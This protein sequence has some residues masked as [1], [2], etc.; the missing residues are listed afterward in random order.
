MSLGTTHILFIE[1]TTQPVPLYVRFSDDRPTKL[2]VKSYESTLQ[3]VPNVTSVLL[4]HEKPL[5]SAER[6]QFQP[7]SV[8]TAQQQVV[9]TTH[10]V[11]HQFDDSLQK[12]QPSKRVPVKIVQDNRKSGAK[13]K[14]EVSKT[15]VQA[16][17]MSATM[18]LKQV[19]TIRYIITSEKTLNSIFKGIFNLHRYYNKILNTQR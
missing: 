16:A 1:N 11:K 13:P 8:H 4:N 10:V 15:E 9:T 7:V 14:P 5:E 3:V 12:Q 17:K 19:T 2:D 18:S 6:S